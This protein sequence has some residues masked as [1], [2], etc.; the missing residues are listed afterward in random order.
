[1]SKL[2]ISYQ[3]GHLVKNVWSFLENLKE[4]EN[5]FYAMYNFW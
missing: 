1:M 4:Y 3:R 2:S 5:F